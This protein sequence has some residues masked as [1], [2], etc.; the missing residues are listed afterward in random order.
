MSKKVYKSWVSRLILFL[1]GFVQVYF[2]SVNTYF[3]ANEVYAGVLVAGFLISLIWSFNVQK[4]AFGS[5]IDRVS[6]ALGASIGCY[7][8]LLTSSFVASFLV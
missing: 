6:Y 4:V 8:G 7:V 1:T 2:V 5:N 3:I